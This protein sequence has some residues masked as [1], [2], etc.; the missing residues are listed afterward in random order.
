MWAF[1][2]GGIEEVEIWE[3]GANKPT[4]ILTNYVEKLKRANE[5]LF[6]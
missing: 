4:H 5:M 1:E 3:N 2:G 6:Y